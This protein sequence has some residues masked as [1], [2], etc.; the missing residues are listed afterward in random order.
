MAPALFL[1][2]LD[3]DLSPGVT[4][5]YGIAAAAQSA[6]TAT[7]NSNPSGWTQEV[8]GNDKRRTLS[9]AAISGLSHTATF[10]ATAA[11]DMALA[12]IVV[13]AVAP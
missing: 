13:K 4:N 1:S 5:A 8:N 11:T 10:D 3:F 6:T 9:N 12:G 7:F 2:L